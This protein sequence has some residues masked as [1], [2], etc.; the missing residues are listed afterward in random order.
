[1]VA[2]ERRP[3]DQK[4][5]KQKHKSLYTKRMARFTRWKDRMFRVFM[6]AGTGTLVMIGLA[7][8]SV[9]TT[10]TSDEIPL[11]YVLALIFGISSGF[12]TLA[13][14]LAIAGVQFFALMERG[15]NRVE[16]LSDERRQHNG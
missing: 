3:M 12:I 9:A 13:A 2:E 11:L 10:A 5:A 6:L 7:V 14:M 1:W 16:R 8:L 15:L 4:P